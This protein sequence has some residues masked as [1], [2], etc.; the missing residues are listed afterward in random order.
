MDEEHPLNPAARTRPRRPGGDRL[1][2]AYHVTYGLPIVIVRPFN[3]YGPFQH[4]EKVIPRF[5]TQALRDEPLTIHGDGLASRDWL[6][7]DDDA[8]A[9][10]RVIEADR[11][12]VAGEVI[13]VATGIDFT[14]SEIADM[15]LG[16]PRPSRPSLR[17][18]V[19]ERPGQVDRHIGSTEKAERLL[20]WRARTSFEHGLER[21]VTWYVDNRAWWES[22]LRAPHDV[23]SS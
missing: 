13:N 18:H 9:I 20:G 10:E 23:Y 4:P 15:V 6:Y 7:V 2:Y 21:T 3:N 8:E 14:V 5:I 16:G 12:T 11:D 19:D 22:V 1:A 17:M